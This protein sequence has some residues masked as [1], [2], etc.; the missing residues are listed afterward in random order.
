MRINAMTE[1][2]EHI[3]LF[4]KPVLFTNGRIDRATVPKSWHCY[5][6]RGS[7]SDPGSFGTLEHKVGVN[8][9]GTILSPEKIPFPRGKDYRPIRGSQNFL[10]E[11]MTLAE[12]CECHKLPVP[13]SPQKYLVLPASPDEAGLFYAQTPEQDDAL[14][15]IG[16]VR[17]DFGR[18]GKEFWH[19]WLPR[20]PEELNSPEFKEE[21]G[22]VIDKLRESVLKDLPSMRSYCHASGGAIGGGVCTQNYGYTVETERHVYRLRCNPIE[23]DYN[24]YLSCFDKQAQELAQARTNEMAIGG[25]QM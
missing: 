19:T 4:G 6:V 1:E 15:A 14:G 2:Y 7:D 16:H 17:M 24:A 20:G 25:V 13:E 21:L 18:G 23:G 12:F 10:G 5:D 9:A 11:E 22:E 3:E 8:H